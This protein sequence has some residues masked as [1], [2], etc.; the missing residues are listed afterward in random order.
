MKKNKEELKFDNFSFSFT[1]CFQ[2]VVGEKTAGKGISFF[3]F[4]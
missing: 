4:M 2:I 1:K 3:G